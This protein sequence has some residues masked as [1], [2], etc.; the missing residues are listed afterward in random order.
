LSAAPHTY[1]ASIADHHFVTTWLIDAPRQQAW[2][3]L[4]DVLGW[5]RWWR[6]MESAVE[7]EPGDER[8]IGS[9][10]RVRWRARLPYAVEFDFL[11]ERVD[12]PARMSG[13]ALGGLE[14]TG[15][16]R[17]F[18]DGGVTAVLYEWHVRPTLPWMRLA[19][20]LAAGTLR[21]N[22]DWVMRQGGEG[23]AR[24][25]GVKLLACG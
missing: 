19:A 25:L 4:Q 7:I 17:L 1:A 22:H 6:G 18:E 9:R 23:L 14:G 11:V 21:R 12:E 16:W 2:D 13:R 5:P 8:R 3:V 15:A 10:Y 24:Q 20:P